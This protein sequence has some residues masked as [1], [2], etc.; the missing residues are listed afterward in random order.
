MRLLRPKPTLGNLVT[1]HDVKA[2]LRYRFWRPRRLRDTAAGDVI[3]TIFDWPDKRLLTLVMP[4]VPFGAPPC[5]FLAANPRTG[6]EVAFGRGRTPVE[7]E[8]KA[9]GHHHDRLHMLTPTI[10][11]FYVGDPCPSCGDGTLNMVTDMP[12]R[13]GQ[14]WCHHCGWFDGGRRGF[15]IRW[16]ATRPWPNIKDFS[17]HVADDG[18]HVVDVLAAGHIWNGVGDTF[19]E[20]EQD[21]FE[22]YLMAV[23]E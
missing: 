15:A 19:E 21:A 8:V 10:D 1:A 23:A 16:V 22:S 4:D 20:A 7:A 2:K 13:A 5:V 6:E 3:S 11:G 14:A 12:E 17:R 18:T 9:W